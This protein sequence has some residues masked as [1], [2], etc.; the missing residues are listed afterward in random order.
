MRKINTTSF[1][2]GGDL[3]ITGAFI[4]VGGIIARWCRHGVARLNE[5]PTPKTC[6]DETLRTS[7][8]VANRAHTTCDLYIDL[9]GSITS[10]PRYTRALYDPNT[11]ATNLLSA[12]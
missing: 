2:H 12:L 6:L 11:S 3:Q 5:L 4:P 9:N 1:I 10:D 8:L 7:C